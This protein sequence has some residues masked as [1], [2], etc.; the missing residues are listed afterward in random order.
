MKGV[1]TTMQWIRRAGQRLSTGS[2]RLATHIATRALARARRL[3][4]RCYGWV[5][6]VSGV[7]WLLRVAVLVALAWVVRKVLTAVTIGVS[8]TAAEGGAPWLMWGSAGV[9]IIAAYRCGHPDWKPKPLSTDESSADETPADEEDRKPGVEHAST[10]PLLPIL[11]DL[12][13]ALARVGTPH[14]HLAVL[15]ADIGTTPERVREALEK[16]E[17]P[18]EAVRMQGRGTS[19]GVKGG[20]AMHPAL[21]P[22]PDD[23]AAVAAG[24]PTNNNSNNAD[25]DEPQE[26][27]RVVR[28][29]DGFT[30]YDLADHH[31]RHKTVGH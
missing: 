12:R 28:R 4:H 5:S 9:W 27:V 22:G 19:T 23:A 13:I 1:P 21:V 25:K 8:R 24:Q 15:A 30:V 18:I 6:A 29:P 11:P 14:A 17:I 20:P 2:S 7:E 3:W 10:G 16:W 26:G 31:R